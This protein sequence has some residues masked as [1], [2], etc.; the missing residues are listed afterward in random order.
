MIR[1]P[2]LRGLLWPAAA[3][4]ASV[5]RLRS[6]LYQKEILKRVRVNPRVI[7]IGNLT[8]GGTGKTPFTLRVVELL[9]DHGQSAAVLCKGYKRNSRESTLLVS[10]GTEILVDSRASG[11]EAQLLAR[12]LPGVPVVVGSSKWRSARWIES[13]LNVNWIVID[14]GFQHLKLSRD[15]NVLLLNGD[16]PFDNGHVIPLGRL[17]EPVAAIRRADVLVVIMDSELSE[18]QPSLETLQTLPP[19]AILFTARRECRGVSMLD[20]VKVCPIEYLYGKKLV[21]FCG[22]AR[23]E[24]FFRDLRNQKLMIED[25][26]AFPDHHRYR[27]RE[28]RRLIL[29]ALKCGAEAFITTAKDAMNLEP[30][31]FGNW[32]CYVFEI[33]MRIDDEPRFVQKVLN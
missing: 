22:L 32:P 28:T 6:S 33:K 5:Q 9:R 8:I 26:L 13:H 17:R 11:D 27:P 29:S 15:R 12:S 30:R 20:E 10:D 18:I 24:Q 23:P 25:C 19:A 21:A 16:R 2:L 7:S 3:A 4:Y 1:H 31:A 14:D